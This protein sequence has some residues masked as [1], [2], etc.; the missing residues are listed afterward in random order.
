MLH[1]LIADDHPVVR[2]GV[3]H[4]LEEHPGWQVCAEASNGREAVEMAER[5]RPEICILDISMPELNGIEATRRIRN[6]LPGTD[7]VMLTMHDAEDLAAEVLAAGARGYVLKGDL[8]QDLANAVE[9]LAHHTPFFTRKVADSVLERVMHGR[10]T[11]HGPLA[12]LTPREREIVQLV[13]E[14]RRTRRIATQLG[15]SEKTVET[16]R[17]AIMRKLHLKSVVDLVRFAIRNGI[18]QA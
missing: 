8:T 18:V 17:M 3:R 4:I 10:P 16:H 12:L 2:R 11:A 15:I 9:A 6:A 1:I 13:A 7:V 14:G 5:L